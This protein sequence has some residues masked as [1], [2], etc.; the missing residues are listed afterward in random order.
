MPPAKR[1]LETTASHSECFECGAN[2]DSGMHNYKLNDGAEVTLCGNCGKIAESGEV[3]YADRDKL[4][5]PKP[6]FALLAKNVWSLNSYHGPGNMYIPGN[7]IANRCMILRLSDGVSLVLVNPSR[8]DKTNSEPIGAIARLA[9]RLRGEIKIIVTLDAGHNLYLK[10]YAAIF[11]NA[12]VYYPKGRIDLD[13]P[14]KLTIKNLVAV[15]EGDEHTK[16]LAEAGL[17]ILF[18][19][20]QL[21]RGL[22]KNKKPKKATYESCAL[23][24]NDDICLNGGHTFWTFG[25]AEPFVGGL[26]KFLVFP[27]TTQEQGFDAMFLVGKKSMF[28]QPLY[29]VPAFKQSV[30]GFFKAKWSFFADFHSPCNTLLPRSEFEPRLKKAY[31]ASFS[32]ESKINIE[33][34]Q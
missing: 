19:N 23:I 32:D 14:S 10:Q 16:R 11:P 2:K 29:D 1:V 25:Y 12:L 17:K 5:I 22:D 6:E 26:F 28:S 24:F 33:A 7:W 18:F 4:L 3:F 27:S 21:E 30:D 9:Q 31:Q 20:G 15:S 13:D 34:K 8:I